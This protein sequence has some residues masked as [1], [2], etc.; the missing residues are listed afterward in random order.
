MSAMSI[1]Q[2]DKKMSDDV[3]RFRGTLDAET[4][5]GCALMAAAYLDSLLEKLIRASLIADTKKADELLG[6]SKPLGT[7]SSR[8]DLAHLLGHISK[9]E[10]RDLQLI[11]KIRN[12]FGHTSNP[13]DFRNPPIQARCRELY[14]SFL[15]EDARPRRRFTNAVVG[16]AA[17]IRVYI[18]YTERPKIRADLNPDYKE[19]VRK[20]A[21]TNAFKTP[22]SEL[23]KLASQK[24]TRAGSHK[25]C[26]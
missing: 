25:R 13:L 9:S 12:V 10:H 21:E 22:L 18:Y 8:I 1:G 6:K 16:L 24:S 15:K 5:R 3:I 7:F 2:R 11:R 20:I 4:D 14:H 23:K 17:R 19:A 26:R